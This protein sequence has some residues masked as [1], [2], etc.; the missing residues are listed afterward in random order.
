MK[1]FV[2][3]VLFLLPFVDVLSQ[4]E[5]FALP[6]IISDHAVMQR[7]AEVK[8]WGWCPGT[9]DLKIVCSWNP[10]DTIHTSSNEY[11][12]WE[13]YI[14]TP[15]EAG[16][17]QIRFYGWDNKLV[18]TVDDILIGETWLCSGQSNMEYCFMW[19]VDDAKNVKED[20][21]GKSIRFFKVSKATSEY[22]Q[23]RIV[24]KWEICSPE[25]CQNFSVVAYYFG[26]RL[27]EKL[28]VPIGLI[29]SYWGGTSIEPWIPDS[30]YRLENSL[31]QKAQKQSLGWTPIAPS[32]IYNAMISP[33]IN[34]TVAGV[35]WYQGEAN[36]ERA[37]D[38][39]DLFGGLIRGWRNANHHFLPFYYV[40]IAPWN[41]YSAQNGACLREQQANMLT[42]MTNVG[43]VT[44]G[45][46][47]NDIS[48]IHP[49][50]KKEVGFR[51]GNMALYEKYN[52][53]EVNPFSPMLKSFQIKKNRVLVTTT[54]SGKLICKGKTIQHFE[55]IDE[56]GK[57][58]PAQAKILHDGSIS[59]FSSDVMKPKGVR[60]CFSNDA[61]PDLFDLNGLPLAPFRT[62]CK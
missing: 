55:V 31:L 38:Y 6:S 36:N 26:Y 43:M 61:V 48:D 51:L 56:T 42:R 59:V 5:E 16:P 57:C 19:R 22:P 46:L 32:S 53:K 23:D 20:L 52:Q 37:A 24:G 58:Y 12:K 54:A 25:T 14:H 3:L 21:T 39:G 18:K 11:C 10:T 8:L 27:N 49:S 9:W 29:G 1:K 15:S 41:G 47:V 17:F 34:Y 40:Q 33:I 62:D 2:Y 4:N 7:N 30:S 45:D 44:I 60:Y 35:I 28:N 13:T 50:L